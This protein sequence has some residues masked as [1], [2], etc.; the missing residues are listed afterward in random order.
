MSD[1]DGSV[2]GDDQTMEGV[3][4]IPDPDPRAILVINRW[5]N[6]ATDNGTDEVVVRDTLFT[7]GGL[8]TFAGCLVTE[9]STMLQAYRHYNYW[10]DERCQYVIAHEGSYGPGAPWRIQSTSHEIPE[11]TRRVY[12]L[13][14]IRHVSWDFY[15]HAKKEAKSFGAEIRQALVHID[16]TTGTQAAGRQRL[17]IRDYARDLLQNMRQSAQSRAEA[18]L[19]TLR[20]PRNMRDEYMQYFFDGF[21]PYVEVM[22]DEEVVILESLINPPPPAATVG[23]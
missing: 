18:I 9:A 5:L 20:V 13:N 10:M 19:D 3:N 1:D 4:P 6:T 2:Y 8:A 14:Q 23:P 12:R 11:I 15:D 17:A 7:A 22:V 16:S 21:W